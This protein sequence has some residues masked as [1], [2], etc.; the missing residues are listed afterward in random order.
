MSNLVSPPTGSNLTA[1]QIMLAELLVA[2][3]LG[4]DS[5][6]LTENI[7]QA[8]EISSSGLIVLRRPAVSVQT[9]F[10]AGTQITAPDL[11]DAHTIDASRWVRPY[12]T[13]GL[14]GTAYARIEYTVT[15]T[16]G[17]TA[18]TL[19]PAIRQAVLLT[20]QQAATVPAGVAS[21]SMGPVSRSYVQTGD[22]S[23]IPPNADVLLRPWLP[24]RF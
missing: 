22:G 6:G 8:G 7:G 5:L 13:G 2:S 10:I 18:E 11:L 14:T 9:L 4:L 23:S 16:G 21:E 24:L 1:D 17:W 3:R 12:L 20:A 15:Y 19:P